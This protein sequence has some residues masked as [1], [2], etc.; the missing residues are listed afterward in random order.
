[1]EAISSPLLET[2]INGAHGIIINVTVS[3]DIELDVVEEASSLITDA[4]DPDALVIWG[5][6]FDP[7]LE[8]TIQITVIATGFGE[9]EAAEAAPIPEVKKETVKVISRGTVEDPR[10]EEPKQQEEAP[11][12]EEPASEEDADDSVPESD[13]DEIMDIL[14]KN[15]KKNNY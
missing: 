14:K 2:A 12:E 3:P 1:M 8:D 11:V 9:G 6:A 5:A 13:F 4:A 10:K 7:S 15:R